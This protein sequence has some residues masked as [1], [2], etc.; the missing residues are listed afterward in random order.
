MIHLNSKYL[1]FIF[2]FV[3]SVHWQFSAFKFKD[4][5]FFRV[6]ELIKVVVEVF[7][8]CDNKWDGLNGL[9]DA[10]KAEEL[11]NGS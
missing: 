1:K 8:I 5:R 6:L 3:W 11:K 9:G 2:R 4:F 7:N 10:E